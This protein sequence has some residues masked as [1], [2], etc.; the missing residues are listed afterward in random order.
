MTA[1]LQIIG[2]PVRPDLHVDDIVV[3]TCRRGHRHQ[4]VVTEIIDWDNGVA[5]FVRVRWPNNPS[6]G[7]RHDAKHLVLV[8]R[9]A[10]IV[11]EGG[12]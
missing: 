4:G 3:R 8:E 12:C 11:A 2:G 9:P 10:A 7:Q 1:S 6:V 5:L